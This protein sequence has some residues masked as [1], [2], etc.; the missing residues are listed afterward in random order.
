MAI[1][2]DRFW[3]W[4]WIYEEGGYEVE[5]ERSPKYS[6]VRAAALALKEFRQGHK[7]NNINLPGQG[8]VEEIIRRKA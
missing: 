8:Y 7:E 5:M 3:V 6:S 2:E 4:V 1:T